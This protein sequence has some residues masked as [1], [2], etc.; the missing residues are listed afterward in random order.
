MMPQM[1]ILFISDFS[2]KHSPGGAQRSNQIIIDKATE[3]GHVLH[4]MYSDS[5]VTLEEFVKLVAEQ[6]YDFIISSNLEVLSKT[7]GLIDTLSILPNHVRLEHD[8]N[9]YL[10]SQDRYTLYS[11]CVKT[12][13]L[14]EYHYQRFIDNY[15]D[16]F[17]NVEIIS[18][19]IDTETFHDLGEDREDVI[20]FSGFLH[21]LK[22]ASVFINYVK[23][24]PDKKFVC[25]SWG[26]EF[27]TNQLQLLKNVEFIGTTD[28]EAMPTL[29]NRVSSIFYKPI[30]DEPFC[31]TIGEAILC[32]VPNLI[33]NDKIGCVHE[34]ERLGKD[35]F[36]KSCNNAAQDFWRI[37]FSLRSFG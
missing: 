20:L 7:P 5:G 29:Y 12:F 15:G 35:K 13:F 10:T 8:M 33:I 24:N 26:E 2:L 18:D 37:L 32:G 31:R 9:M 1:K 14:T 4:E 23:N 6:K 11:N 34:M 28:Y 16:F 25:S 27:F 22:G 3:L 30:M 21:S 19:P 17:K 36:I